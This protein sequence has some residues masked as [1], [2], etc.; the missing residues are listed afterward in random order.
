V[1]HQPKR[2]NGGESESGLLWLVTTT[3]GDHRIV[4]WNDICLV[5]RL[6]TT[7]YTQV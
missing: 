2:G 6:G 3:D 7:S 5:W 1:I 4:H